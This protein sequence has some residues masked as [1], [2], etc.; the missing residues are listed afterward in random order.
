MASGKTLRPLLVLLALALMA[1]VLIQGA[2]AIHPNHPH[3]GNH[4][5]HG[6]HGGRHGHGGGRRLLGLDGQDPA[7]L[8]EGKATVDRMEIRVSHLA[9][10]LGI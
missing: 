5:G 4:P 10:E 1:G 2:S 8:G 6:R 3:N 9:S 7:P